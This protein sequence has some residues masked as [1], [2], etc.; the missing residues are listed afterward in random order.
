MNST[1]ILPF[2]Q[3]Y[4]Y[5]KCSDTHTHPYTC[6]FLYRVAAPVA[7]GCSSIVYPPVTAT[8]V[9]STVPHLR[10]VQQCMRT[11]LQASLQSTKPLLP[12][13]S[14]SY[15]FGSIYLSFVDRRLAIPRAFICD[16]NVLPPFSL[17]Q[18]AFS[19]FMLEHRPSRWRRILSQRIQQRNSSVPPLPE[20]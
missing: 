18:S 10:Q 12:C 19:L 5:Y 1:V 9:Y 3:L 13:L 14:I 11:P 4:T 6:T 7:A 8:F 16:F 2:L 17:S 20:P 15:H